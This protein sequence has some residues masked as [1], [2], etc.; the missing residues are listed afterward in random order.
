MAKVAKKAV[1]N[2]IRTLKRTNGVTIAYRRGIEETDVD[3][4]GVPADR[5][6]SIEN[7]EGFIV[8]SRQRD[9]LIEATDL[10]INEETI[11]PK[12]MDQILI[13]DAD[14][15]V[16]ETL[17]VDTS[18]A[19]DNADPYGVYFRVHVQQIPSPVTA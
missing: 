14:G 5:V 6:V 2:H 13:K 4:I 18:P 11:L 1:I 16:I 3:F 8:Q 10:V 9:V 17:H 12:R 19:Y 15:L 7:Q